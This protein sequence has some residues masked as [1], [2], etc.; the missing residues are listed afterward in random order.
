MYR[1]NCNY[2][3]HWWHRTTIKTSYVHRS[4]CYQMHICYLANN[5]DYQKLV[6]FKNCRACIRALY[7]WEVKLEATKI[8]KIQVFMLKRILL[9]IH[10]EPWSRLLTNIRGAWKLKF[11][12][13]SNICIQ[14]TM[15][16]LCASV[17]VV[18]S[19]KIYLLIFFSSL[20]IT[21]RQMGKRQDESWKCRKG[22]C[23]ASRSQC[24][25]RKFL[26]TFI[27]VVKSMCNF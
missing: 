1:N 21:K 3:C 27:K 25:A 26:L 20:L 12:Y 15:R 10:Y 8:E 17:V 14:N 19:V 24:S 16:A 23:L 22:I 13:N 18:F 7:V 4:H 5:S 9:L 2:H 6:I 11:L